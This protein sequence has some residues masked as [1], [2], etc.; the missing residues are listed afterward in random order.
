MWAAIGRAGADRAIG[1]VSAALQNA[2]AGLSSTVIGRVM[3]TSGDCTISYA[4]RDGASYSNAY[5]FVS[6]AFRN[7]R[8]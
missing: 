6:C 8:L 2:D 7:H 5:A 3:A 4:Y 1:R